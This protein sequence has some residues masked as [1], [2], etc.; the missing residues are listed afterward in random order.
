MR[1][2][3]P[4]IEHYNAITLQ[5]FLQ[6]L[7]LVRTQ[8]EGLPIVLGGVHSSSCVGQTSAGCK[9]SD[10][11]ADDVCHCSI[12]RHDAEPSTVAADPMSDATCMLHSVD[13]YLLVLLCV[14]AWTVSN[15]P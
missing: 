7:V 8:Y 12:D 3:R 13:W 9:R 10:G 15:I 11:G 14:R 5:A 6:H 4:C 2:T 1:F